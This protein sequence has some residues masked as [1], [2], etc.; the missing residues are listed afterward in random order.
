[1]RKATHI[2]RVTY[3]LTWCGVRKATLTPT[4]KRIQKVALTKYDTK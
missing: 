4:P 2:D 3:R 1:V